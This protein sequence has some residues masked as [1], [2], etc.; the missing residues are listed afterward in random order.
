MCPR[1]RILRDGR[2]L[3]V[4]A[5]SAVFK[6]FFLPDRHRTLQRVNYVSA[7]AERRGAMRR[8]DRDKHAG[9]PDFGPSEAMRD[10]YPG[11]R[12]LRM[13]F[14]INLA[15]FGK[16]HGFVGLVVE[17]ERAAAIRLLARQAIK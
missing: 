6:V 2:K 11:N 16:G 8:A 14:R 10:G 13:G 12:E 4:S 9:F 5:D 3:A 15:H 7:G 1:L 17:V